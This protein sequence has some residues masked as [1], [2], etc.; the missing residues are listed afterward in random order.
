MKT[1]ISCV[2]ASAA[3]GLVSAPVSAYEAGDIVIRGGLT[4]VAPNE[5][6]GGVYTDFGG[7]GSTALK[8]GVE[9]N[10]QLGLNLVYFVSPHLAV[11]LLA[12]TPFKHDLTLENDQAP[13]LGNGALGETKQLPP[14]L[15][16]LYYFNGAA[17]AF[18]PY[19]GVGLNYTL[20]FEDNFTTHREGQGFSDLQLDNS[21][22][23]AAQVGFDY[24]LDQ[25]WLVNASV[26]YIDIDTTANF[27]LGGERSYVDVAVDPIVSSL[28]IGYKF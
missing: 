24:Q 13:L 28:M 3:L 14:T 17:A 19:A 1:L 6:S 4:Q 12:A 20:F 8:V 5:E 2:V 26:R 25:H 23:L 15:S 7:L 21:F 22:G 10:T 9:S 27:K 18:R 16:V 11:E